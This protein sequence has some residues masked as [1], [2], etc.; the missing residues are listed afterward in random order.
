M[1]SR[2]VVP[3]WAARFD[4]MRRLAGMGGLSRVMNGVGIGLVMNEYMC[5]AIYLYNKVPSMFIHL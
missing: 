5:D 4:L 2:G 3:L 1:T